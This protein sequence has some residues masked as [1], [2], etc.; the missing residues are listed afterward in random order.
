MSSV[1][2][3]MTKE[4]QSRAGCLHVSSEVVTFLDCDSHIG[5]ALDVLLI[6]DLPRTFAGHLLSSDQIRET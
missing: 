4:V 2:R 6:E 5:A 1:L 3:E